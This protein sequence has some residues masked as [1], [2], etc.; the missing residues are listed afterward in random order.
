MTASIE[1]KT[2]IFRRE[3]KFAIARSKF[4]RDSSEIL[5]KQ[6]LAS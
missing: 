2:I 3:E 6:Q 5:R 1:L 4:S